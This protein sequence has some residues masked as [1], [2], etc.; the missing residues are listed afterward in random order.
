M[1]WKLPPV[2][3]VRT[4]GSLPLAGLGF[5]LHIQFLNS[6]IPSV[7]LKLLNNNVLALN[8]SLPS[9]PR[10]LYFT[11]PESLWICA[12]ILPRAA[13]FYLSI[14]DGEPDSRW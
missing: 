2:V 10:G 4:L 13:L 7:F 8:I 6:G 14:P 3:G 12:L 11:H 9:S 5:F 1:S